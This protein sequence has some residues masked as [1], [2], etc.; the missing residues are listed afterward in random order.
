[1]TSMNNNIKILRFVHTEIVSH[2][3][4]N[5]F[6]FWKKD[7]QTKSIY[8]SKT[9]TQSAHRHGTQAVQISMCCFFYEGSY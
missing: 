8:H 4:Q 5:L 7:C 3:A 2:L 9:S 6:Y 1:M